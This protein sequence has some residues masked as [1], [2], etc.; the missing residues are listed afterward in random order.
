M[1][2]SR[3]ALLALVLSAGSTGLQA[4][5]LRDIYELSLLNDAQLKAEEAQYRAN[6]ET[7]NLEY[8]KDFLPEEKVDVVFLL[9]VCMWIENWTQLLDYVPTISSKLIFESNGSEQQQTDQINYLKK[10]YKTVELIRGKSDD[11]PSQK[12]RQL[13]YC[14]NEG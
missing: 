8:I 5:S 9:S 11:D 13:Y 2:R 14:T 1:K 4:E 3:V 10:I 6:L 12:N 7:E